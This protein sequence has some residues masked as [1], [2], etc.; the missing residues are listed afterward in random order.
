MIS[1]EK[2]NRF[3][4]EAGFIFSK[5]FR[6]FSANIVDASESDLLIFIGKESGLKRHQ[7][8]KKK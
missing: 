4:L 8:S 3:F 7:K 6:S 1:I 5:K 2:S